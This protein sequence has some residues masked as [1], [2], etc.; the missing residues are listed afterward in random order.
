MIPARVRMTF[1]DNSPSD[2][3][4]CIL[5]KSPSVPRKLVITFRMGTTV[6]Q[7]ELYFGCVKCNDALNAMTEQTKNCLR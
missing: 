4:F 7:R 3:P 6:Q 1:H 5:S 2:S